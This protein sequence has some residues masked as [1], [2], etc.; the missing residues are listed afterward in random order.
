MV[1]GM[2][3]DQI[4]YGAAENLIR[5]KG[6]GMTPMEKKQKEADALYK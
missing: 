3:G 2:I 5:M 1:G 6:G 4:G